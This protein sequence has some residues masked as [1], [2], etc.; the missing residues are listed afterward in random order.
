MQKNPLVTLLVLNWNGEAI[1]KECLDS[2]LSTNYSPFELLV[3]DNA[4]ND[5]SLDILMEY[6]DK[7]RIIKN[8]YNYGYAKGNNIGIK[9][10][11]GKYIATVN[12]DIVVEKNWLDEAID[13]FENHPN[14]GIISCRQMNYYQKNVIDSLFSYISLGL[15]FE[16]YGHGQIY[17][18]HPKCYVAGANGASAIYRKELLDQLNGFKEL[19]FAYN[20]E[21]DLCIR[22]LYK[23]WKCVFIPS[24]VVYHKDGYSFYKNRNK[25]Y[26]L[27]ERNRYLFILQNYSRWII[28]KNV[29]GIFWNELLRL[30]RFA[31]EPKLF[32]VYF[33]ARYE[34]C[35]I[36]LQRKI[37][38]GENIS[39]DITSEII[40]LKKNKYVPYC[41]S[42]DIFP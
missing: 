21:S 14:V 40:T 23:G 37:V 32:P 16:Q 41:N 1:I 11:R 28:L 8:D 39:K 10:A 18:G 12:N 29:L 2:L 7:I 5:G 35:K 42:N 4:S 20:E 3:I 33:K 26:F 15:T 27:I 34:I 13:F 19:Y 30:I 25:R 24:A 9:A 31:I 36:L 17:R 38:I 22:S 6:K